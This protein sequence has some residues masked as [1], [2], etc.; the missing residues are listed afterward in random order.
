MSVMLF[1][2]VDK[3]MDSRKKNQDERSNTTRLDLDGIQQVWHKL[4]HLLF[5]TRHGFG[6]VDNLQQRLFDWATMFK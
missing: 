1:C 5:D 2:N 4:R 6:D 3:V